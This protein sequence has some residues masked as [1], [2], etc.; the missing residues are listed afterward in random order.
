MKAWA[1][2]AVALGLALPAHG[3]DTTATI[4]VG[5]LQFAQN[6]NVRMLSEDLYLSMDEV[7]VTYE[8]ENLTDT[9]QHVLIAFPMPDIESSPYEMAGFPTDDP[10]NFFGFSTTF[11]G[12]PVEAELYQS[13]FALGVD[14]TKELQKLGVPLAPHLLSTE[15]AINA[16]PEA[17]RQVLVSI[18]ALGPHPYDD[19]GF[20]SPA[21]T[22][23]SAYLWDA[24]F[25][26][27][28]IVEVHHRYTPGLGGTVAATFIDTEYGQRAEYEEKYCLEDNLVAAVER[29][30]TSPDEPWSAP[31]TE[32]WLTYI[33][34]SGA[35]WAHSIGTFRLT[36]DKGSVDNFVS[37][38]GEGVTKT[39]P[40]TFEMVQ[41]DFY[42]WQDIEVLFVVRRDDY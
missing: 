34:S 24:V 36:V 8:F 29:T 11:D 26:A 41:E 4:G 2:G 12:Q 40:T 9:D 7:R 18:G 27:G 35:N 17:D 20:Y 31:F 19:S 25:P 42:P 30:L 15:D 1:I 5:G 22:L 37:F 38:C 32:A 3:N 39:G 6:E 10:E 28:E 23:K 14:R 16:L 21:W 13:A 33:L